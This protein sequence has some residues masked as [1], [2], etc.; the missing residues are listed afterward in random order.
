MTRTLFISD[1]HLGEDQPDTLAAFEAFIAGP[2]RGAAALYVLGD[3]FEYW[4]GDDDLDSAF[5]ARVCEQLH[6]LSAHGTRI[7]FIAGNRDFLAGEAF[8]ARAG[9][10]L[11]ADPFL[12]ELDGC[13]VL[14]SH[15]DALCTDDTA[16]QA[17]RAQVREPA[18]QMAFLARPLAERKAIIAGIRK[19]SVEAK[20]EKA[21]D[22]MDVNPSAVE[23][24]LRA[25]GRPLFIHGH[26]HRPA[27]H[28]HIVDGEPCE[29]W[30]LADWDDS[31]RYLEWDG[32]GLHARRYRP[33]PDHS[34][35]RQAAPGA[36]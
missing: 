14:L 17:F 2:A 18:W 21:E 26:T 24:L 34:T 36:A 4:A 1:L 25:H 16:Y 28:L 15:G 27:R 19:Q 33:S 20:R 22:I 9:L 7:F 6:T 12:I 35:P 32:K 5:P 29:R 31:A 11:L 30:V 13:R 8:A 3:L 23:A 10:T